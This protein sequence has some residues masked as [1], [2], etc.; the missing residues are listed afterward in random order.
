MDDGTAFEGIMFWSG[1]TAWIVMGVF[2]LFW[3]IDKLAEWFIDSAKF[4]S[5]IW[6][7]LTD[8]KTKGR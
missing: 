5:Y 4:K 2:G 8:K 7:Y 6:R 1:V 3:T